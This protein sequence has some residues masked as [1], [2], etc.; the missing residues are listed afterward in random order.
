[1][2]VS[3]VLLN[4]LGT[5]II[6]FP[7][8]KGLTSYA[9]PRGV[10]KIRAGAFYMCSG[11]TSLSIPSGPSGVVSIGD[12]AFY[13]CHGLTSLAIPSAVISIEKGT[14]YNCIKLT[15]LSIPVGVTTIADEAFS[16]CSGISS[17]T[18]PNTVT[19]IG[20]VVFYDCTGLS[21]IT[22]DPEN[23]AYKDVAGILYNKSGTTLI[24][25]PSNK[26][27]SSFM[28]PDG[29]TA[30]EA[31]AFNRCTALTSVSL[32]NATPPAAGNGIFSFCMNLSEIKVPAS[33]LLSYKAATGWSDYAATII[34][35]N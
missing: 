10:T 11:L 28:V 32:N 34:A 35:M 26:G 29:I 4:K 1:M 27:I 25:C 5:E 22:V 3:G 7:A 24:C 20:H 33:S 17:L 30:I 16:K 14:F 19:S 23:A 9:I 8:Q 31:F 6:C 2:D 13:D 18:I 12:T 15:S 21:S